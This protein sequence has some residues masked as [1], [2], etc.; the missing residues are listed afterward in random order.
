MIIIPLFSNGCKVN[1][2]GGI[3]NPAT[4]TPQPS[5]TATFTSTPLPT[6]TA[7]PEPLALRVNSVGIPLAE[8]QAQLVQI[9]A[10]DTE[11]GVQRTADE[12]AQLALGELVDQ[13]LLADAAVKA[14]FELSETELDARIEKLQNAKGDSTA[15]AGWLEKN[16]YT[17]LS[18]RSAL[19]RS[20]QA[21]WQRDQILASVPDQTEQ[22]RA[23]QILVRERAT[24]EDLLGRLQA[25]QDF[26]TIAYQYD[27]LTGGDLGWFPRG[28]LTQPSVEEAAFSLQPGEFSGIIETKIGF[29]IIMVIE[30]DP[31]HPLS[32]D[33][34]LALQQKALDAWLVEQRAAA[35]IETLLP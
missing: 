22:V 18:F 8:Y 34:R 25:G 31:T 4:E 15:F 9:Q 29:H 17:E 12:Q 21:A 2:G 27:P 32:P 13:S 33:A 20:I 10:A 14:G 7:T 1:G 11:M 3:F 6:P 19:R 28:Y 30:R 26:S 5:A 35:T 16:G 23:R 24:A